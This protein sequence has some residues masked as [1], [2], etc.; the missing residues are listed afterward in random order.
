MKHMRKVFCMVLVLALL[1]ATIILPMPASAVTAPEMLG[2]SIRTS[3]TQGLRFVARVVKSG[4]TTYKSGVAQF[5]MVLMPQSNVNSGTNITT[6]TTNA[7]VVRGDRI[8][9][10]SEV[11]AVGLTYDSAYIY[12]SVILTN[13]PTSEYNTV[14]LAR[15]YIDTTY[16]TQMSRSVYE[17]A[18]GAN[19]T[20]IVATANTYGSDMVVPVPSIN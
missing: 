19:L 1:A 12:F 16:G 20:D 3:G 8:M 15:P 18:S 9:T 10:S 2:A 7:R 4:N 6:S 11:T 17:V 14:I 13:I 5:G